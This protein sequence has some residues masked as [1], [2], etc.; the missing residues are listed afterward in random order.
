MADILTVGRDF[1]TLLLYLFIITIV[2]NVIAYLFRR[3][4]I[5]FILTLIPTIAFSTVFSLIII[6]NQLNPS[7]N[8]ALLVI[9]GI[10]LL[11]SI[12]IIYLFNKNFIKP[13]DMV[14][15]QSRKL[16]MGYLP[17]KPIVTSFGTNE[18]KALIYTSNELS[19][20]LRGVIINIINS[21][22]ELIK[23]SEALASSSEEVS[24]TTEEVT[25]TVQT[26][27]EGAQQQVKQLENVS[28]ILGNMLQVVQESII[29]INK[30]SQITLDLAEQTNLISLNA[31]I[32][33][34]KAGSSGIGF[35]VVADNVRQLSIESRQASKSINHIVEKIADRMENAVNDIVEA[36]NNVTNVA[37]NTAAS[38]QE[39]AA[40]AEE[41]SAS[42]QE[43]TN[44]A[45][46]LTQLSDQ[47]KKL[48]F[49]FKL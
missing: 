21:N 9:F 39:A 12:F 18:T 45:Q 7:I 4:S 43:I 11:A 25:A 14:N 17:D 13:L 22:E 31:A 48:L 34:S 35:S 37:E 36:I 29:E 3:K 38:S 28:K 40:A 42:L 16:A 41:Q 6:D 2:F 10:T 8:F 20:T 27:A 32:E 44:Q 47:T 19:K 49:T 24:A 30:T 33:A 1:N 46:K 15:V 23:A 5:S 26:I